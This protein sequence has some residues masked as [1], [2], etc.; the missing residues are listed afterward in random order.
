MLRIL[1]WLLLP[2]T[3]DIIP[4]LWSALGVEIEP[5]VPLPVGCWLKGQ[6]CSLSEPRVFGTDTKG[7]GQK[8]INLLQLKEE[9]GAVGV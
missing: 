3:V 1:D 5:W 2:E 6:F 8:Q 4:A 7:W 9:V